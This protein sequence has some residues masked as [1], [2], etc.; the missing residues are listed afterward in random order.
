MVV[1]LGTTD[2]YNT[3]IKTENET[4]SAYGLVEDNHYIM[5]SYTIIYA[6]TL[7][8]TCICIKQDSRWQISL[9]SSYRLEISN[10]CS[11]LKVLGTLQ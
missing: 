1:Q 2:S 5:H 6:R 10:A 9:H 8:D 4:K 3:G 11:Y 7:V